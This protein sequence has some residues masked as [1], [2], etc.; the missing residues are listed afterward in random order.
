MKPLNFT[1]RR[2]DTFNTGKEEKLNAFVKFW[3]L[4]SMLSIFLYIKGCLK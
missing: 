4:A 1:F 2:K 3:F